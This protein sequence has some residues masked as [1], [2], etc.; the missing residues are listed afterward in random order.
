MS[1]FFERGNVYFN[2]KEKGTNDMTNLVDQILGFEKGSTMH[3]DA[4]DAL[5]SA[6]SE[7]NNN[8]NISTSKIVSR[9]DYLSKRKN[10]F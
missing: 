8:V 9:K 7:L 4:P 1:G 6:I 2:I 3:D 10:K 5:Q